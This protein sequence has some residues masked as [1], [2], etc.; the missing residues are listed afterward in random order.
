MFDLILSG[1]DDR[2]V[3][4]ASSLMQATQQVGISLGVA[5]I[6]AAFFAALGPQARHDPIGRQHSVAAAELAVLI[7]LGLT[8]RA[9]VLGF[10]L[11]DRTLGGGGTRDRDQGRLG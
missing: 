6:G 5:V 1:L 2:E 10:L 9:F 11:P 3:G 4:S 7:I 8:V